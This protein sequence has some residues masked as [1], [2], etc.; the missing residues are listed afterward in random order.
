MAQNSPGC[1]ISILHLNTLLWD[2]VLSQSHKQRNTK[3]KY[4]SFFLI[5]KYRQ[6]LFLQVF[7][8]AQS[9]RHMTNL[10]VTQAELKTDMAAAHRAVV[11]GNIKT[12]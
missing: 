9:Y 11:Y 7:V 1:F 8:G 4:S 6:F 2:N 12:I 3:K 10:Y 5:D